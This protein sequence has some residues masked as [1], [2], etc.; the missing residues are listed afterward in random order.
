MDPIAVLTG[1]LIASTAASALAVDRAMLA[2][3]QAAQTIGGW[4]GHDTRFTRFRGDGW[5]IYLDQPSLA[6]RAALV[7]TAHLR[8]T[9]TGLATRIA[10]ALGPHDGLGRAGLSGA[11]GPAFETSGRALDQMKRSD[12]I[13]FAVARLPQASLRWQQAVIALAH[14]HATR[15]SREQ[16][17][18]MVLALAPHTPRQDDIAQTLGITRQAVQGRLKSAGMRALQPALS[19]F[20]AP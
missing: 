12:E 4:I 16:A 17:E 2:L 15:W 7:L 9:D 11:S 20:E 3:A 8:A 10:I 19:A 6:L 18:A 5:Q 14:W 13:A 1:D